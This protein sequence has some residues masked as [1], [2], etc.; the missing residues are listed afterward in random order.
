MDSPPE[1]WLGSLPSIRSLFVCLLIYLF[2]CFEVTR[3]VVSL[4]TQHE[5]QNADLAAAS[6]WKAQQTFQP[7]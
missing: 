6:L 2:I 4:H 3:I 7:A 5:M 1:P